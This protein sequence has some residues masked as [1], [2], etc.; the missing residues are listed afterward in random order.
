MSAEFPA[1]LAL[2]ILSAISAA[3]RTFCH[4]KASDERVN[5]IFFDIKNE[6]SGLEIKPDSFALFYVFTESTCVF[7][8]SYMWEDISS[9]S[10]P[11]SSFT[12]SNAFLG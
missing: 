4:P 11:C 3:E 12:I 10:T 6:E 2:R 9:F 8:Q 5:R 1:P 7:F